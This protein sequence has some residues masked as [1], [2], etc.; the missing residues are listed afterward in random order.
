LSSGEG[1]VREKRKGKIQ[2]LEGRGDQGTR[3]AMG[4][5]GQGEQNLR[6]EKETEKKGT[7]NKK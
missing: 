5:L 1:G 6:G 3:K 4:F 7:K 2:K